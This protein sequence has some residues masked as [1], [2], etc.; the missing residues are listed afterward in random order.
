MAYE[1]VCS[2]F[3]VTALLCKLAHFIMVCRGVD[4]FSMGGGVGGVWQKCTLTSLSPKIASDWHSK[5][6][7]LYVTTVD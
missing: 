6:N 4:T 5:T 7:L 2:S 3:C 1:Q